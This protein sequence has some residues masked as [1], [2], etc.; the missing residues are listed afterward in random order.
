[1][2]IVHKTEAVRTALVVFL[3]A[4]RRSQVSHAVA[5]VVILIH[6]L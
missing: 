1:M 3:I 2:E 4:F 5:F 6:F